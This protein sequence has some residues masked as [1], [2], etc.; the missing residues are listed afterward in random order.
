MMT[1]PSPVQFVVRP[2][3]TIVVN[4]YRDLRLIYTDGRGHLPA[5]EGWPPTTWG[6]SVGHWEDDTL[7]IDTIQVRD[8]YYMGITAPFSDHAHYVERLRKTGPDRIEGQM[9]SRTRS[10]WRSR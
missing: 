4:M 2:D 10:R 8:P 1:G 3:L 6:D 7:V 9:T 5:A